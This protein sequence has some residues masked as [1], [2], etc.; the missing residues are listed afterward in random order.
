MII[1]D[2]GSGKTNALLNLISQQDNIDKI[3]LYAKDLCKPN[4]EFLI[5]RREDGGAK[6]ELEEEKN[7]INFRKLVCVKTDGTSF[8][9]NTFK[10]SLELAL[11]I[12]KDKVL[13]GEAKNNQYKIIKILNDLKEH[14]PINTNKMNSKKR[15]IN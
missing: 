12:Y 1:G 3:Y 5:K 7:T 13:L 9:F 10:G 14:R 8:N 15:N 6:H 2:S 11:N 4:Y